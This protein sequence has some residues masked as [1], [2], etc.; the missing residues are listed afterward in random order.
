M[1]TLLTFEQLRAWC[2][3]HWCASLEESMATEE[4][5]QYHMENSLPKG[6][7]SIMNWYKCIQKYGYIPNEFIVID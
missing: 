3:N 5:I 1:T 6:F 7:V 2:E 4:S